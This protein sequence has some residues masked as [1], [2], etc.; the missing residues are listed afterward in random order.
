MRFLEE[1]E[2]KF[3]TL[4]KMLDEGEASGFVDYSLNGL[5]DELNSESH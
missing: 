2:A 1:G 4:G 3:A 5:I